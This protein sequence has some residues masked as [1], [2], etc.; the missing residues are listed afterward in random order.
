MMFTIGFQDQKYDF[1]K[2]ILGY[3]IKCWYYGA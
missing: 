3:N 1:G 2:N